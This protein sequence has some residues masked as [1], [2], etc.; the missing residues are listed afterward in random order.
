MADEIFYRFR[1]R[2]GTAANLEL[3]NEIPL[4][5]ELVVE[6]DTTRM[7]L[8]DGVTRYNDLPYAA[9]GGTGGDQPVELRSNGSYVQWRPVTDPPSEWMDLV[10]LESLRGPKGD[11]GKSVELRRG[12]TQLQWRL[13]GDAQWIDLVSLEDLRGP[14]GDKGDAGADAVGATHR[15]DAQIPNG[16]STLSTGKVSLLLAVAFTAPGRLRLYGTFAARAADAGRAAGTAPPQGSGLLLEFIATAQLLA[17]QLSPG[18]IAANVEDP[19]AGTIYANF[20]A[21]GGSASAA[22]TYLKLE[23]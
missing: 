10:S 11:N 2:G 22:I 9:G 18:I 12:D 6:T 16:Q 19:V 5:R 7:K 14:K 23:N 8:G 15:A 3:V 4:E 17:A 1:V 20:E 13:Q 21:A